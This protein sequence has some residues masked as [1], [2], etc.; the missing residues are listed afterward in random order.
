M[1]TGTETGTVSK[2]IQLTITGTENWPSQRT[3]IQTG[4]EITAYRIE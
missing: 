3:G 2:P 1:L 4:T